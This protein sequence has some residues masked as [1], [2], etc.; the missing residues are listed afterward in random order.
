MSGAWENKGKTRWEFTGHG[1]GV[2]SISK[3]GKDWHA[4]SE[5]FGARPIHLGVF[6]SRVAAQEFVEK[7]VSKLVKKNPRRRRRAS[8][9]QLAA[10]AK[11]AAMAKARALKRRGKRAVKKIGRKTRAAAK[12]F[13]RTNPKP[14]LRGFQVAALRNGKILFLSGI[15]LSSS[16]EAASLFGS[17]KAARKVA[18]QVRSVASRFGITKIAVVTK[19]DAP[20]EIRNFLQGKA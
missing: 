14:A 5:P 20:T 3:G 4:F 12:A 16:R 7:Q 2:F 11:F 18:G 8:P 17:L 19:F 15:G 13:R 1:W 9:A 10:R 6:P